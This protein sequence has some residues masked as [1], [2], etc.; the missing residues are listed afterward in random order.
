MAIGIVSVL[1]GMFPA[2]ISVAP[3]SPRAR[4]KESIVPAST[5]GQASGSAISRNTRHSDAPNVRAACSNAGSTCSR[6]A[7][8][9]RYISG[10]ATTAAAIT[11]AGQEKTMLAPNWSSNLP[12]G[13]LRPKSNKRRKPTTGGGKTRGRRK[14]PSIKAIAG[15]VYRS[16]Q[17]AAAR[18]TTNVIAVAV[19]LV[20]SDIQSGDR[21]IGRI[22]AGSDLSGWIIRVVEPVSL[23]N[24][25][26]VRRL[27]ELEER[28]RGGLILR[29]LQHG[30]RIHNW[31]V[32]T[33][34][35]S[36]NGPD[37]RRG[38]RIGAINQPRIRVARCDIGEDL[39][40]ILGVNGLFLNGVPQVE[41]LQRLLRV[42]ASRNRGGFTQRDS[43]D[44][45]LSQIL[46]RVNIVGGRRRN[47]D[48]IVR[49]NVVPRIS[50]N[51]ACRLKGI[52]LL[53]SRREKYVY[54]RTLLDL[55]LQCSRATVVERNL[56]AGV[57][58]LVLTPQLVQRVFQADGGRH[59]DRRRLRRGRLLRFG[60][61]NSQD[62]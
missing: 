16:R 41:L 30:S 59:R 31:I 15:P 60:A 49:Y 36:K 57:V 34:R 17:A 62:Q 40:N 54:R 25:E 13:T 4:A 50:D 5:P 56:R 14:I 18:P 47:Q 32:R 55:M 33:G 20:A 53:L 1:P 43:L 29:I 37:F 45:R 26:C 9:V 42:H 44:T 27:Q 19:K 48:Q 28:A 7:R 35:S 46:K 61:A 8:E 52:H 21:S 38:L 11:V 23:E 2:T 6:A 39:T 51:Q 24:L 22:V 3:N 12:N 10:K 58:T